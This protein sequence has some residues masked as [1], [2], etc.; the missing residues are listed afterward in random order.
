[1]N[2]LPQ[3]FV[4]P[5]RQVDQCL[6]AETDR[7]GFVILPVLLANERTGD[8]EMRP[9]ALSRARIPEGTSPAVSAPATGP[10]M[11]LRSAYGVFSSSLYSSGSGNSQN[12]S[13]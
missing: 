2:S 7:A 10:P 3:I 12:D 1:M 11:L 5:F 8:I 9:A 13:P 6:R 4:E